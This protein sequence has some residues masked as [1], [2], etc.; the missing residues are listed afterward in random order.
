MDYEY[1]DMAIWRWDHAAAGWPRRHKQVVNFP[2]LCHSTFSLPTL[3][4]H[5]ISSHSYSRRY[6]VQDITPHT[7]YTAGYTVHNTQCTSTPNA[8]ACGHR[9]DTGRTLETGVWREV[10]G[11]LLRTVDT[12]ITAMHI[13]HTVHTPYILKQNSAL[14]NHIS[15]S[16]TSSDPLAR[17]QTLV[18][19]A[20]L[21]QLHSYS[22]LRQTPLHP[23]IPSSLKHLCH[24]SVLEPYSS[25]F[26]TIITPF[27][28]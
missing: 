18:S 13:V 16:L 8:M 25:H 19:S 20:L 12:A 4:S 26:H 22:R 7:L 28:Q 24:I 17:Q 11:D 23:F 1:G 9:T 21:I 6:I 14:P 5:L 10:T 15:S 2:M 27:L 3:S